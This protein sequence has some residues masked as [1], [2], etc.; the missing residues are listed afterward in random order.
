MEEGIFKPSLFGDIKVVESNLSKYWFELCMVNLDSFSQIEIN[1][2]QRYELLEHAMLYF[3]IHVEGF[4][5]LK[6]NKVLLEVL[7]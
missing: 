6:S 5:E 2:N 7:S 4:N 1:K 3:K